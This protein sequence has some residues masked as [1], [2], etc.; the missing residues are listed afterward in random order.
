MH[1]H[2]IYLVFHFRNSDRYEVSESS[3]K[4]PFTQNDDLYNGFGEFNGAGGPNGI[5]GPIGPIA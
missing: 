4:K 5:N 2:D 3:T 1:A